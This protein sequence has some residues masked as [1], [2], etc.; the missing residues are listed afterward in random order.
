MLEFVG[1]RLLIVRIVTIHLPFVC[2]CFVIVTS[3]RRYLFLFYYF[4]AF[5]QS[6]RGRFL[7]ARPVRRGSWTSSASLYRFVW[8]VKR[9][10]LSPSILQAAPR[11]AALAMWLDEMVFREFG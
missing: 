10:C 6:R 9:C 5:P 4:L 3:F 11:W 8:A 2:M 7:S 1:S